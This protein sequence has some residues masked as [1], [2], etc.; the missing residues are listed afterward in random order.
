MSDGKGATNAIADD[1]VASR[2]CVCSASRQNWRT[3]CES[4][5]FPFHFCLPLPSDVPAAR[6]PAFEVSLRVF[7]ALALTAR[8]LDLRAPIRVADALWGKRCD[9]GTRRMAVH[10]KNVALEERCIRR[11]HFLLRSTVNVLRS[12][13]SAIAAQ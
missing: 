6:W 10:R 2:L 1:F 12:K 13:V 9:L 3:F 5:L 8:S 11:S 4:Q 7:W